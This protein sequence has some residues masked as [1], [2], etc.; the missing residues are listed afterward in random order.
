MAVAYA[1]DKAKLPRDYSFPL[2]PSVLDGPW[3]K[4][5]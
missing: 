5:G 4:L 1:F 2:P 3:D